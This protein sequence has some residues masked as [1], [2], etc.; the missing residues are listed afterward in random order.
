M[1]ALLLAPFFLI[2]F[3]LLARLDREAVGRAAHFAPMAGGE[4]AAYWVYQFSTGGII[5]CILCSKL[6][7]GGWTFP[8]GAAATTAPTSRCL[9]T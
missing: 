5:L 2:R 4:R 8:A 3:G 7:R 6:D 9:A 1:G